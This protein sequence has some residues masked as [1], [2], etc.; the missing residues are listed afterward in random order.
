M[1]R[2]RTRL[3]AAAVL[4]VALPL[5]ACT[6]STPPSS[7]PTAATPSA[8]APSTAPP[9]KPAPS[10]D[11]SGQLAMI[12]DRYGVTI[13]V[14]ARTADGSAVEYRQNDRFGYAST[15]KVFAA[16]MLLK[17]TTP[18][19]RAAVVTF[20]EAD[21]DEAGYSPVTTEHLATGLTLEQLAEAA[22]RGSDNTAMNL[23]LKALGGPEALQQFLRTL[24]DDTTV[25]TS[26]EP[27][28]N[29]VTPGDD[30]NTTTPAAFTTALQSLLA[31][32]SIADTMLTWMRGN[33]TGDRLIR[34]GAPTGWQ[35]ADKS[36]GAGGI[37]ND[38]AV[39][40]RPDG[41]Q[42]IL[43]ILTTTDDPAASYND[44]VVEETA[45]VVLGAI[46]TPR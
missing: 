4:T 14:S 7:E 8:P 11:V 17:T 34:A 43:A 1:P 10:I 36:G 20:T 37:R 24:G 40:T 46:P 31:D 44:A 30:N 21:I 22:V 19:D 12:E 2:T 38:I 18:E 27:D 6:T 23:V 33:A 42:L 5:S 29:T 39:V 9:S 15:I 35:V 13:G 28:L 16:A 41:E 32:E 25:V 26:Y 3:I 45:R